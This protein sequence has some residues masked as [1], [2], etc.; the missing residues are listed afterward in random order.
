MAMRGILK[1]PGVVLLFGGLLTACGASSSSARKGATAAG[2]GNGTGGGSELALSSLAFGPYLAQ[3]PAG[4]TSKQL[5]LEFG[6]V[7][8]RRE[9]DG[10]QTDIYDFRWKQIAGLVGTSVLP[11]QAASGCAPVQAVQGQ[12]QDGESLVVTGPTAQTLA[13]DAQ[14]FARLDDTEGKTS[15]NVGASLTAKALAQDGSSLASVTAPV[16]PTAGTIQLADAYDTNLTV[17]T[18]IK[19]VNNGLVAAKHDLLIGDAGNAKNYNLVV[20]TFYGGGASGAKRVRCFL[21]PGGAATLAAADYKTLLPLKGIIGY[22]A[23]VVTVAQGD[24]TVWSASIAGQG[25]EDTEVP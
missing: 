2:A 6:F 1:G 8:I 10:S 22:F 5:A 7:D 9:K 20:V 4:F 24:Q 13:F 15:F 25:A 17:N 21:P 16:L 11:T 3:A 14:G 23:N 18:V 19:D 12:A